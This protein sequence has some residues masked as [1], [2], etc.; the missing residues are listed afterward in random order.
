MEMFKNDQTSSSSS[1]SEDGGL[2]LKTKL[3]KSSRNA[4]NIT[5]S[6]KLPQAR[7]PRISVIKTENYFNEDETRSSPTDSLMPDLDAFDNPWD[8]SELVFRL[9]DYCAEQGNV[10]MNVFL[11]QTL[12]NQ[13]DIPHD[14]LL[15]YTHAYL[16]LLWKFQLWSEAIEL[17]KD[18]NLEPISVLNQNSTTIHRCCYTCTTP[19]LVTKSNHSS[20]C[21]NC[22]KLIGGCAICH[23]PVHTL[24][25]WCQHC[26]H[27]GHLE[28]FDEW[29][30]EFNVC[31]SGCGH[32]CVP[33]VDG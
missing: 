6:P 12:R 28:C 31:P 17:I 33:S 8:P 11:C 13:I 20:H 5:S 25:T 14:T 16:D 30:V 21:E 7:P 2:N 9:L 19:I 4:L 3:P 22:K 1:D 27:G 23:E 29:F 32:G 15:L 18:S 10:Q 24:F 26:S